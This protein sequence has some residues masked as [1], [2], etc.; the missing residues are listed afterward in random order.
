V[1]I[2]HLSSRP[3]A[4]LVITVLT[5]LKLT[6]CQNAPAPRNTHDA[7]VRS[8]KESELL[9]VR[10]WSI[11]DVD[12]ILSHYSEDAIWMGPHL[13]FANGREAIREVVQ[14]LVQDGS[15]AITFEPSRV[16]IA[17]SG[18]FGYSQGTYTMT[19][20]DPVTKRAVTDQGSY[21]R[22][23]RKELNGAWRATQEINTS[24]PTDA[25]TIK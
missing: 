8:I 15:L 10:N 7:D 4:A 6:A 18:E 19:L 3:A 21:L 9:W 12:R 24:S 14:R 20:T 17:R 25:P 2:P 23:Y 13:P 11:R 1:T 16:E 22:I 5:L